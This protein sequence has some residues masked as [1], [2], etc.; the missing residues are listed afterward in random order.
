MQSSGKD[1]CEADVLRQT[2]RDLVAISTLPAIWGK[3]PPEGIVKSLSSV[4]LTTLDLDLVHIRLPRNGASGECSAIEALCS[5]QGGTAEPF[6]AAARSALEALPAHPGAGSLATIPDPVDG[7]PLRLSVIP[8][9]LGGN[10]GGMVAGSRRPLFPSEHERLLLGVAA[11]Q[12][13]VVLQ[14]HFA[15]EALQRSESRFLDLA[16]AAPA[17]LWVTE[18]D[19]GCSFLSRGWQE[20]TGQIDDA[21]LGFGWTEALHPDDRQASTAAFLEANAQHREF[22]LEHRVRHVDGSYRWV[23][24]RAR[25]RFSTAGGFLGFVGSVLDSTDRK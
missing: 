25:P 4:L 10:I 16:D 5:R 22:S 21:G 6:L 14:R 15:E 20:F 3:L 19:G 7:R 23:I 9:G 13:A 24:A 11:N 2:M 17:M 1:A 8:F 18:A 12:A